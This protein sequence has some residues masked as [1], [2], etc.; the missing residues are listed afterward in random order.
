MAA[1]EFE[2]VEIETEGALLVALEGI[3]IERDVEADDFEA[4]KQKVF[5]GGVKQKVFAGGVK[6]GVFA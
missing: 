6:K 4:E 1:P 5:V 2:G 3:E